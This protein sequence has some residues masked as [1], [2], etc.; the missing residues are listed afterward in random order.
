MTN[1]SRLSAMCDRIIEAGW[2][3]AVVLVP[4]FFNIYSSRVFEPDKITLLRSI[5]LL[6][7]AAWAIRTIEERAALRR[8]SRFDPNGSAAASLFNGITLRTPLILPTLVLVAVY[9]LSTI[10]SITPYT[11]LFGSYQRLQGTYSTFSYIVVFLMIVLNMRRRRQLDR[12]VTAIVMVSMPIA[13]YG[14]LQRGDGTTSLDPL[15]WGG[16]VTSR[17]ASNMGNPIFVAAYLIMAFFLTLGR[18]VEAFRV[19]LREDESRWSDILRASG[20]IFVGAVQLIA[21]SFA[22]SR[23]PLLGWLPGMFIFG[24]VGLLMLRVTL[25]SAQTAPAATSGVSSPEAPPNPIVAIDVLKALALSIVSLIMAALAGLLAYSGFPGTPQVALAAAAALIGGLVPLLIVAGTRRAAARWLWASWIF[26]SVVGAAG[27]FLVNFSDHPKMVELRT[28]GTFGTLGTLLESEGGTGKVRSLIWEG[29]A[30]LVQAHTPITF[31]DGRTDSL[32]PIRTVIGYG[33]ESMYV[34][35]NRFYPPDLA[36]Y[37]ARNASP[38]RSHNET[39]DSLV[40]TGG[41][42]F[43]AEQFLFISVFFFALKIVGWVPNRKA[44]ITFVGMM[45]AGGILGALGLGATIGVNFMGAGWPGGVTAGIVLYVILFALFHFQIST[46]VYAFT[47]LALIVIVDA[48]IFGATFTSTNRILDMLAATGGGA[49]VFLVF[50][51]IA[52]WA[53]AETA[54]QPIAVSGHVFIIIALFGGMLAHYLEISL[55]GIAIAATRTYF[56]AFAGMLVVTGLNLVRADDPEPAPVPVPRPAL[57]PAPR[58]LPANAPRHKKKK[59]AARAAPR[60]EPRPSITRTTRGWLGPT[61]AMALIGALILAT[62]GFEFVTVAPSREYTIQSGD[63]IFSIAEGFQVDYTSILAANGLTQTQGLVL[64]EGQTILIPPSQSVTRLVWD[65]LTRLPYQKNR[66]SPGTLLMFAVTWIFGAVIALT[67]LRRRDIIKPGTQLQA[68]II[69]A[70]TS[71]GV[72]FVYWLV[73]GS[74]VLSALRLVPTG[75]AASVDALVNQFLALAEAMA[76]LLGWFY[77]L[78]FA[79]IAGISLS[80]LG[81]TQTRSLPLASNLGLFSFAPAAITALLLIVATNFNA[82]RAD[83]I[84]KQGQPYIANNACN[85][86]NGQC[87]IAIAHLKLALKYAPN[88]DFYMLA[89]GA[90]YLNKS[91]AATDTAPL[92]IEGSTFDSIIKLNPDKTAQLS[93]RDA[94]TAARVTLQYAQQINPLNTDH[95]ANLARLHR[96][97]SD[98]A[99]DDTERQLRLD[100]AGDFYRQATT[101]SPNNAQLWNEWAVVYFSVWDMANRLGNTALADSAIQTAQAKLDESLRLDSQFVDTYQYLASLYSVLNRPSDVEAALRK[102]LELSPDN[103]D[104]WGRLTEQLLST[105]NITEAEKI[106]VD[107]VQRHPDFLAGWRYLARR[108]YFPQGRMAE[109]IEAARRTIELGVNDPGYWEDQAALAEMLRLTGNYSEALQLAQAA[110]AAAPEDSKARVQTV[111]DAIQAALSGSTAPSP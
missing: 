22:N 34:A 90:S 66:Q 25:H 67:E 20:Y 37:E 53:F 87:D 27:L 103:G 9:L 46:R 68:A 28:Q 33:P 59:V 44:A 3:A 89:L 45:V 18:I 12:L 111:I 55:A 6:M 51:F 86:A 11:S 8:L 91:A 16:D 61:V 84:F 105:G 13:F 100:Q 17:V 107:F 31:P 75:P 108:I 49:F 85:G 81:D 70:G 43:V 48:A 63:T 93:R 83:V 52:R 38:D 29:S 73:H 82:I 26:F 64:P 42:G 32:N 21:F 2:L 99:A 1:S 40:I 23:G 54:G 88:E 15:P 4:L 47:A 69:Y 77:V 65:S 58:S 104:A 92:L 7:V 71:I 94:L 60:T 106:T 101:L 95:S 35:Y 102:A 24:L 5:A 10:L 97:W 78:V 74:S 80:L 41:I 50:F 109:A 96:R 72:A 57:E 62:L 98:L 14:L 76:G 110:L 79:L 39:W 19:I 30:Q 36:H 56:W